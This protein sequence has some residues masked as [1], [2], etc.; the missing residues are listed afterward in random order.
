MAR[1]SNTDVRRKQIID[2]LR[3]EMSEVGFARA[4]TR[5]IAERAGLAPGL[6]HYHFQD[7]EEIL[8]ALVEQMISDAE[9][10]FAKLSVEATTPVERLRAFVESRVGF[11]SERDDESVKLWVNLIADARCVPPR[12]DLRRILAACR[13]C[14]WGAQGICCAADPALAGN[15]AA[16][17]Q[18]GQHIRCGVTPLRAAGL[19]GL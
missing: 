9:A 18:V 3:A 14:D 12:S 19:S 4:S 1:P 5:S 6:V 17:E 10:R 11:G 16:P 15:G 2:A 13:G 7:K 8:L